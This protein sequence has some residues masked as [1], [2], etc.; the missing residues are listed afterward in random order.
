[1][2]L[3]KY[4]ADMNLGTRSEAKVL[5]K[6]KRVKVNGNIIKTGNHQVDLQNDIVELDG[7]V[8]SYQ[9]YFYYMLNKPAGVVSS[10]KDPLHKTVME[11]IR[12]EDFRDDLFMCGRLDKDTEG[13]LLI[14]NNGDL[15]YKLLA[16]QHHVD[17]KYYIECAEDLKGEDIITLAHEVRLNDEE[18]VRGGKLEIVGKRTAY[19]TINEGKF[20][21]VK[22]MFHAINNE[23]LYLER[24]TFGPLELD[25][26]LRHGE[27]RPLTEDEVG[28]LLDFIKK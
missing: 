6:G 16:P 24:V 13:L 11:L 10:T 9:K 20:H 8:I 2:R 4:L 27:Y 23:V 22:R 14:M 3:D 15:S 26:L 7:Q 21:Q 5:L 12:K 17:K 1:M 18:T 19:L 25:P 28:L